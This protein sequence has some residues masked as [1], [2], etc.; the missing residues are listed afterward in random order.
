MIGLAMFVL[1][2]VTGAFI[3]WLLVSG[4]E[5]VAP[6]RTV[7]AKRDLPAYHLLSE[8]DLGVRRGESDAIEALSPEDTGA[9]VTVKGRRLLRSLSAGAPLSSA[10]VAP[11]GAKDLLADAVW[12]SIPA[13]PATTIGGSLREGEMVDLIAVPSDTSTSQGSVVVF[14]NLL[15]LGVPESGG[16]GGGV[17]LAV[18][19]QQRDAFAAAIAGS[20]VTLTRRIYVK[21]QGASTQ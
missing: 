20:F 11:E 15:V 17:H 14:D 13:T 21:A 16:A 10:S 7:V 2:V 4:A 9:V 6:T 12:L 5:P 8:D 3:A 1:L 18:R 19:R